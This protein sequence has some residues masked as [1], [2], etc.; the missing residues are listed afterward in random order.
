MAKKKL[1]IRKSKSGNGW[2]DW[3]SWA[4]RSQPRS[5]RAEEKEKLGRRLKIAG[6]IFFLTLL[7]TGLVVGFFYLEKYID[8]QQ[9]AAPP[10]GPLVFVRGQ[11][12]T[13]VPGSNYKLNKE[14]AKTIAQELSSKTWLY[15]IQVETKSTKVVVY[16]DYRIPAAFIKGTDGNPLYIGIP[17]KNDPLAGGENTLFVSDYTVDT[18]PTIEVVGFVSKHTPTVGKVWQAPDV[19]AALQ[20]LSKLKG[21]DDQ[22]CPRKP[23]RAEIASIDMTNFEGRKAGATACHIILKLKNETPIY[24]GA[25]IGKAANFFE[26]PDDEKLIRLYTLYQQNKYTLLEQI[27]IIDLIQPMSGVPR[28]Q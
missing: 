19:S 17:A 9:K 10:T 26:S 5:A 27:K 11:V 12:E 13:E 3:F 25:A 4:K 23:L 16:A 7:P 20:L 1:K 14:T 21:M 24:W 22:I 6:T 28:P 8:A 15:N 18:P 2:R